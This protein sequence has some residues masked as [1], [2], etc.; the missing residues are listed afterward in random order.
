SVTAGQWYRISFDA[1]TS[2]NEQPIN[3][4]VR[5]GGG[6]S[7]GYEYLMPAAESFAGTTAWRRYAFTFQ[8][9]KTVIATNPATGD[10]GARVDFERIQPGTSLRIARLEMVTLTPA[11]AALQLGLPLN[12]SDDTVSV[13][14]AS[15]SIAPALCGMFRF[16]DDG[17]AVTWPTT[18]PP[19]SARPAYTRD[20]TLVD[21]DGDGIADQQDACPATPGGQAVNARGCA[22][23]Q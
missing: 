16:F 13:D 5:R 3:T 2:V 1:A 11:Q 7:N 17:L 21:S 14:C 10:L 12:R 15:L 19:F 9:S 23:G 6:G 4:V 8:A 18:L 20:T 22:L